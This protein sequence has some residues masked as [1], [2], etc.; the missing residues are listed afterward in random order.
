MRLCPEECPV[1]KRAANGGALV[2]QAHGGA[3]RRG[4]QKGNTGGS[5]RPPSELR[6]LARRGFARAIPE[7]TKIVTAPR[8]QASNADKIGAANVLGRYGMGHPVQID[9]VRQRLA[10]Q[11]DII[12]NSLPPDDADAL[13]GK[14]RV[15]WLS[16]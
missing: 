6:A 12:R 5:G 10:E 2:T 3:L 15:V 8:K 1:A 11:N 13:L 7:M 4:S 9:D 16:L 14:L